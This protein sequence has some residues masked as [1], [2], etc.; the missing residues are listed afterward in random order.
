MKIASLAVSIAVLALSATRARA[1]W[2]LSAETGA[3]YN[4]NLA[5]A[6]RAADEEPDW[7]WKS[8]V[9]ATN[10][11]QLTRDLRL[12]VSG[13]VRSEVWD[14]FDSFDRLGAGLTTR[15]RY[16]FGL[17][18]RAPW[19][20]IENRIG[21]D[22]F[23]DSS[24]SNWDERLHLRGGIRLSQRIALEAGYT[25]ENLSASDD[26][27]D[28]SSQGADV[29]AVFNVTSSLQ[30]A[31]GY[32]YRNGDIISYA[33]P[34]RPDLVRLA[35]ALRPITTFGENPRYTAY[36]LRAPTSALSL[37]ASYALGKYLSVQF[38]YTYAHTRESELQY[39]N[40]LVEAGIAFA[41]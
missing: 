29:F 16:R 23:S 17:G 40:H 11:F 3:L 4:S 24:R 15:L 36:K 21:Y 2:N 19:L 12:S 37:S 10:G 5:N 9:A 1:D 6:D 22:R 27:F 28:Q 30:V 25:F 18:P 8:E 14:Q 34:P 13:D 31:L 38:R 26:F 33:V 39:E 41:Y 32:I 35:S 7:A 20:S